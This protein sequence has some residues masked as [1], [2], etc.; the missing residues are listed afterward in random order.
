MKCP[1]CG[2]K[3]ARVNANILNPDASI[4]AAIDCKNPECSCYRPHLSNRPVPTL[5][6]TDTPTDSRQGKPFSISSLLTEIQQ[7]FPFFTN[8]KK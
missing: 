2:K 3:R 4:H 8:K 7:N 6:N 5:G 1:F